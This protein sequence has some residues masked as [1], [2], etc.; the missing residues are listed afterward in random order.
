MHKSNLSSGGLRCLISL[1]RLFIPIILLVGQQLKLRNASDQSDDCML[2]EPIHAND[3]GE[4][5]NEIDFC[6][7]PFIDLVRMAACMPS[8]T[9]ISLFFHK[10]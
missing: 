6:N 9:H 4:Q 3:K 5:V 2:G 10:D 7:S 1:E 8:Y